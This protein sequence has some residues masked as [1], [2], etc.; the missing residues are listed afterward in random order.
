MAQSKA[1]YTVCMIRI[2]IPNETTSLE[3]RVAAT[4]DSVA[5][6]LKKYKDIEICI[7][8]D[9]GKA[10]GFSNEAYET[11]GA[12]VLYP[13]EADTLNMNITLRVTPLTAPYEHKKG[14]LVIGLMDPAGNKKG[15][16]SLAKAGV[17]VIAMEKIPRTSRAQS[18]DALSSQANIAGYRSVLEVTQHFNR[19]FPVMMT[20]AG[21]SKPAKVI[22]LGVGV[23]GLQ[24]IATARR[25]GAM[26]EAFDIRPE[27]KEQVESLGAKFIEFNLGE[28]K[29]ADEAGYAKELSEEGKEK[30]QILLQKYLTTADVVITTAQIPGRPAPVLVTEDAVKSMKEGSVIVDMAAASGGNCPLTQVDKVITAYGVT[31]VGYT[32]YPAMVPHDASAFYARNLVNLLGLILKK[33]EEITKAV[34]DFEDDIIAEAMIVYEG[35]MR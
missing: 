20:A 30:Q 16:K 8:E 6:L 9:A 28:E 23:A 17:N 4:P 3:K 34:Y 10:A 24:A 21:S 29:T 33:E 22:I 35:E 27:V 25:L 5:R 2:A 15:L 26:V 1:A 14:E 11:A 32:N 19:F 12:R 18:M 7:M 13:E 31:L